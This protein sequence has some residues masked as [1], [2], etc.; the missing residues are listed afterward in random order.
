MNQPGDAKVSPLADVYLALGSNQGA[1]GEIL[2]DA[3]ESIRRWPEL[4]EFEVSPVYECDYVGPFAPQDPYLN[5]CLRMRTALGAHEL[6]CRTQEL[7][8]RAGRDP[9]G[10]QRP[11]TL[12][13]DLVLHGRSEI[14]EPGLRV[15]HPR[16]RERRFVLRPLHDLTP[17]LRLPPDGTSVA[18]LLA[19]FAADEQPLR[20][21]EVLT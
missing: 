3:I 2:A 10:H 5:L 16:L 19:R 7:E 17:E 11:R 8:R 21:W 4:T 20:R 13:I 9:Q 6:L 12:D 1:R 18:E 15:P 14:D